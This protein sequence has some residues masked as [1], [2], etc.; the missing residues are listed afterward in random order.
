MSTHI[1]IRLENG[2]YKFQG[3]RPRRKNW[4]EKEKGFKGL[5]TETDGLRE[6]VPD[7]QG[8]DGV[9]GLVDPPHSFLSTT[10]FV[11][12]ACLREL[13]KH[14][15][16][17]AVFFVFSRSRFVS[18]LSNFYRAFYNF[19]SLNCFLDQCGQATSLVDV[20]M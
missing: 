16:T 2:R 13:Q 10:F 4:R 15:T 17:R 7:L 20:D 1:L 12:S 3:L 8:F 19:D 14:P 18:W 9:H 5:Q 11:F 6:D